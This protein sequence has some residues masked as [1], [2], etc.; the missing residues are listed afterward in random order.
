MLFRYVNNTPLIVAT[1]NSINNISGAP[2]YE[3]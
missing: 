3:C 1:G 2:D